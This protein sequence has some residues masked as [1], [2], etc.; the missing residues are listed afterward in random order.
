MRFKANFG[1]LRVVRSYG[2]SLIGFGG[3][4]DSDR[5]G[6]DIRKFGR[7]ISSELVENAV[8]LNLSKVDDVID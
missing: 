8:A 5:V 2:T 1:S 3:V 4:K 6:W 7:Y